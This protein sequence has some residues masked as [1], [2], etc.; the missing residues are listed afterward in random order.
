[1]KKYLVLICM[2]CLLL[3]G[4]GDGGSSGG[5]GNHDKPDKP[6]TYDR[7]AHDRPEIVCW[8]LNTEPFCRDNREVDPF[9]EPDPDVPTRFY[10]GEYH[11]IGNEAYSYITMMNSGLT[12]ATVFYFIDWTVTGCDYVGATSISDVHQLAPGES[13]EW[14]YSITPDEC[15]L[16][17]LSLVTATVYDAAGFNPD[18]YLNPYDWPRTAPISN[19]V[20]YWVYE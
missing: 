4:C 8:D 11:Q 1:M 19:A 20:L 17:G 7:P 12:N 10:T 6:V 3:S 2:V 13:F 18:D 9:I 14:G 15:A 5:S 16:P